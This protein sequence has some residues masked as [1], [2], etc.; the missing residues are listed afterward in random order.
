MGYVHA[1]VILNLEYMQKLFIREL[2]DVCDSINML[3]SSLMMALISCI[4][5]CWMEEFQ[6]EIWGVVEGGHDMDRLNTTVGL[7]AVDA[8]MSLYWDE[9]K[10]EEKMKLFQSL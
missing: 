8:F 1:V 4:R 9:S 2:E 6:A 3:M 10:V 5:S 7:S